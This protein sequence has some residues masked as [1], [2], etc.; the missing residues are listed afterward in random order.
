MAVDMFLKL[1][2]LEG[3]SIDKGNKGWMDLLAYSFGISN[4]GTMHMGG[5]GGA[6]KA[7]FQDLSCTTYFEKSTPGIM[8]QVSTGKHWKEC[9]LK[10]RKAG[11]EQLEYITIVMKK[12]MVTSCNI[13]G[14]GGEERLTVNFSL[15][16]EEIKV[17]YRPQDERGKLG[18]EMQFEYDIGGNDLLS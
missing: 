8:S 11:G 12:V 1:G 14:S 3:E 13:G 16:F 10:V 18:A 9:T 6:G 17:I 5:G 7:N 15:N 2:D 4:S